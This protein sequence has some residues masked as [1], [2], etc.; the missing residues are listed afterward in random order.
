M[1]QRM[2]STIHHADA[3]TTPVAPLP[4]MERITAPVGT[5]HVML[6]MPSEEGEL[7]ASAMENFFQAC[8]TDEVF[9]LELVGTRREQGFV[10]R[11]SSA[12]QLVL[13]CKQFSAQYPQAE[14]HR[15]EPAADPLFL[16][17][18]EHAVVGEFAL[19]QKPWMPLKTFSGKT[20]TEP[21][22]DPLAGILAA[23]E[24]LG[25]GQRCICQLAL[26]RAP[27]NWIGRY[28]RKSVEHPL[29]GERDAR[30][31]ERKPS[32]EASEGFKTML[33]IGGIFGSLLFYHWYIMHAWF[34]LTLF[35][36]A[37]VATGIALLWW[38]IK[39]SRQD[40]YDM[41]LVSEKLSRQ[42]FYTHL[43]VVAIGQHINSTEEHL[44]THIKRL[45]V[46]YRQFTL[47]SANSLFLKH[48][49]YIQPEYKQAALLPCIAAAFPYHHP[50]LKFIHGGAPGPDICN[51]L[52]LS[53]AF[54]LPQA[55][56]DL[57]LIRRL[58]VK[59]L[60]ASPQIAQEIEQTPAP[61]LPAL[62]GHS[63]HRGFS[64]PVYLPYE[65]LFSHKFL[66]ARS[67]Y[68][69]ST[70]IQLLAQAA[71]QTV[72]DHT[73]QPGLFIIDP[74]KDLI[75]DLLL[76]IP[77]HR[78]K[79]VILL[80][81]TDTQYVVALNPLDASM[82]FTRDQAVANLMSSFERVWSDF[83]GPRMSYFL[84]AVCLL[85]Y[86]LNQKKVQQGQA[87]KQYTLLDINPLLQYPDYALQVLDEL[88]MS[89]IWH[90]ELLVW[91]QNV[92]FALPKQS[93][94]RSEVIMPIVTKLGVFQDN[95][96]IR[97][98]VGQP[99]TR[100]PIHTSITEGKI[101]LCALSSRDMDDAAVNVLGSTL[102]NLLHRAFRMQ[103]SL[104]LLKRR[105][106]FCA[107][108][109]FHAFSGGDYDRLLS[110]DGKFG[111]SMLLATQNLKRLNKIRDG[112][113]EMVFSTCDNIC[114][115]N[116]SAAD[117]KLLEEELRKVVEQKH[118]ISQPRLHCY[119]RLAITGY[120]VQIVS[121][122]LAKPSSWQHT[123]LHIRQADEI[124]QSNQQQNALA[125]DI[126][127]DYA[128]HLSQFLNV[129]PFAQKVQ[130][131]AQADRKIRQEREEA[132]QRAADIRQQTAGPDRT[133]PFPG[134][135]SPSKTKEQVQ[136]KSDDPPATP[137]NN[138]PTNTSSKGGEHQESR[139]G[140][141]NHPRSKRKQNTTKDP[142]GIAPP[143]QQGESFQQQETEY[144]PPLSPDSSEGRRL[145][146]ENEQE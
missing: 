68:G 8:A 117:A 95:Q 129:I 93:S 144:H 132:E 136:Q 77:P 33:L 118:I 13:L 102:I 131:D 88:D 113:L 21:G 146:R 97:K 49:K 92:Y 82:G 69:K 123:P 72:R 145:S 6:I 14:L 96:Q 22:A 59:H 83:W 50:W 100:A 142:V 47:S 122:T 98:I 119:A 111:C 91:W 20:L 90:Q 62:I 9:G 66:V 5:E 84:K 15:I 94:F 115:F 75:E 4:Q 34:S 114:A 12:K 11:A 60:L 61:L 107:V 52:E 10:L 124:R 73:P 140:R 37:L 126:D 43:R 65:T 2:T 80:D 18:G 53:G 121:V 135:S 35:L 133:T 139:D 55:V 30:T 40:I 44:K 134:T 24:P 29:Q 19:S 78:S 32:T 58:S 141:R 3:A 103:E 27:D 137:K 38:H 71:M 105:K 89:E 85:L 63:R 99:I 101:V 48:T 25:S 127:R 86:T 56:T 108:D 28:I 26:V 7:Q 128:Q 76:L 138:L 70:L 130:R 110:E 16:R 36:I 112:L 1:G 116:V 51:G 31:R 17:P 143:A 120:P 64:I 79:D 45:E 42:A 54:H 39:Q 23:M 41:K 81:L 74:H 125:A 67:R 104:P 87:K 109:E 57:P 46:A 106:V